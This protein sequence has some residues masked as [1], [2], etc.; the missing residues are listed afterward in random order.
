MELLLIWVMFAVVTAV[1]ANARGRSALGWG[2]LGF[3]FG[4]FAL[5]AVLV[6]PKIE[7]EEEE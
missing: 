5:I 7:R 4:P 3:L 1:A 6:M 2:L